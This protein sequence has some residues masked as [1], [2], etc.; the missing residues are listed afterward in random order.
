MTDL[1]FQVDR[2]RRRGRDERAEGRGL[3]VPDSTW[4]LNPDLVK[5]FADIE[6]KIIGNWCRAG[7]KITDRLLPGDSKR[8]P[9]PWNRQMLA[10]F[11]ALFAP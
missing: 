10:A 6:E 11:R 3:I 1:A 5:Q 2:L 9:S 8:V 7:G 4:M